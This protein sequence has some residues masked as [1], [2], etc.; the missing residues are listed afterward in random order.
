MLAG[1]FSAELKN[2]QGE[3]KLDQAGEGRGLTR[4]ARAAVKKQAWLQAEL[5]VGK[6]RG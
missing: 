6:G 3:L 4:D 1:R 5:P 2:R